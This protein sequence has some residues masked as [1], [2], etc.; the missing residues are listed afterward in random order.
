MHHWLALSSALLTLP[1]LDGWQ[2]GM[3]QTIW[4]LSSEALGIGFGRVTAE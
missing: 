3:L 2:G 4:L 1:S